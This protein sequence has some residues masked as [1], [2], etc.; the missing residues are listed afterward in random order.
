MCA[1]VS[2]DKLPAES[3]LVTRAAMREAWGGS[4]CFCATKHFNLKSKAL[5]AA[6]EKVLA[7]RPN[8][9]SQFFI[10][11]FCRECDTLGVRIAKLALGTVSVRLLEM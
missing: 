10:S 3:K 6:E 9:Q 8:F 5:M 11:I 2:F 7:E 4:I 1:A